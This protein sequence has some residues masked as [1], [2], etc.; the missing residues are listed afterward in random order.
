MLQFLW[1]LTFD[2]ITR[3]SNVGRG[4]INQMR[5]RGKVSL[6]T[7]GS[8]G[9]GASISRLLAAEGSKVV[10]GDISPNSG[11]ELVKTIK[12]DGGDATFY[13]LNVTNEI[14]W[15]GIVRNIIGKFGKIDILVNNAGILRPENVL[16]TTVE[17]WDEV[18]SVNATGTFIGTKIVIPHMR[19]G[20]GG[21]I[22]NIS[23]A[24][25]I[26]G[27]SRAA[28]YHS[29]KGAVRIF[30]KL[31]AVQY[32]KDKIR[33]NSV[34]PGPINTTMLSNAYGGGQNKVQEWE[35]LVPLGRLGNPIDIAYGVLFLASD[36]SSFITG[37][38]L[39][40]DGGRTAI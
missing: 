8:R 30:S 13:T 15:S 33:V 18:M 24:G 29:S 6:I 3:Y 2:S 36:E 39:I 25:G 7:G 37:S 22:V 28:A 4:E 16:D 1:K 17:T 5:V 12:R 10:I 38:E 35:S 26:I 32:A 34:H 21:S 9:I 11:M 27:S 19:D 14:E 31:A 20:D 40:I 23:S